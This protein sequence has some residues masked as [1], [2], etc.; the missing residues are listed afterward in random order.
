MHFPYDEYD[1]S[2]SCADCKD[3][4]G[5]CKGHNAAS[6]FM[7]EYLTSYFKRYDGIRKFGYAEVRVRVSS[8]RHRSTFMTRVGA[9]ECRGR[10]KGI[11]CMHEHGDNAVPPLQCFLCQRPGDL[12]CS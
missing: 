5:V 12:S 9:R 11:P 4:D 1:A 8:V 3:G 7:F 6:G 10:G 2:M